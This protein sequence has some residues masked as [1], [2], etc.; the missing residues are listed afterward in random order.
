MK[1]AIVLSPCFTRGSMPPLGVAYLSSV[2]KRAGCEVLPFDLDFM[3]AFENKRLSDAIYY[4]TNVS[5]R[6]FDKVNFITNPNLVFQSLFASK[7]EIKVG[8]SEDEIRL[9]RVAKHYSRK[10]ADMISRNNPAAVFFSTYIGN[11]WFSLLMAQ[12]LKERYGK[13]KVVFGGPGCGLPE[14]QE[15]VL[16][17]GFVDLCVVGEGEET[18]IQLTKSLKSEEESNN[19]P[20][21]SVIKDDDISYSPREPIKDLDTL[22]YPDFEDLPFPGANIRQYALALDGLQER[23]LSWLGLGTIPISASR[24]CVMRCAFCAES[25]YWK[26]FRHRDVDS[27]VREIRHQKKKYGSNSF[28]FCDSLMNFSPIWIEQFCDA[29]SKE[30][31]KVKFCNSFFRVKG[32]P[33]RLLKKLCKA[34]FRYIDYGAESGSQD[35]LQLMRKGTDIDAVKKILVG[36]SRC[37]ILWRSGILVGFPGEKREDVLS[38]IK[39][40]ADIK[41]SILRK[42]KHEAYLPDLVVAPVRLEPYSCMYNS[43]REFKINLRPYKIQIPLRLKHL[44]PYISRILLSWRSKLE[45]KELNFRKCLTLRYTPSFYGDALG[46][47]SYV[48]EILA[49]RIRD[50]S[51][52]KLSPSF[53]L[54]VLKKDKY[55]LKKG[56]TVISTLGDDGLFILSKFRMGFS[57]KELCQELKKRYK[58]SPQSIRAQA[59]KI[60]AKLL[61]DGI[62]K[63]DISADM[64][65]KPVD[66]KKNKC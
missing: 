57:I 15:I 30:K 37:G 47:R 4:Y 52:F 35:I 56:N 49:D 32:L 1:I 45:V 17:F 14:I 12:S 5:Y 38:T 26:T 10:Y 50:S 13:I 8:I 59:I 66:L 29:I 27:V 62:M 58:G 43:P 42:K 7:E 46:H 3:L 48:S 18:V 25:G 39:F 11:L 41:N 64:F 34:G 63:F 55:V 19:I 28:A 24:G 9:V 21:I 23:C 16:R 20:G 6:A 40:M 22:P 2:L 33:L 31:I 60:T 54:R 36:T 65:G 51:K 61:M 44:E 53:R